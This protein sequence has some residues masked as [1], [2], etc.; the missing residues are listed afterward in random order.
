MGARTAPSEKR[1]RNFDAFIS[2]LGRLLERA[3]K[4][5]RVK[6]RR[7]RMGLLNN[8]LPARPRTSARKDMGDKFVDDSLCKECGIC[9]DNCP[10]EAI[11]LQPKPLFDMDKCYGCWRCFNRCPTHAI[12]TKR[13]RT[14]PYYPGPDD[15]LK[16][17]LTPMPPQ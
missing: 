16:E 13:F 4:G 2:G 10:Y 12:Y 5:E 15:Q 11:R 9:R 3:R 6:A 17:K 8:V 14:G 7:V 1:L